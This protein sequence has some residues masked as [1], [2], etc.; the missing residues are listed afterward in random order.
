MSEKALK[1]ALGVLVGLVIVYTVLLVTGREGGA[2]EEGA[3]L[4]RRFAGIAESAVTAVVIDGPGQT[5]EL[6]RSDAG[7]LVNGHATDSAAV[8]RFWNALADFRVQDLVAS[9]PTNHRRL[10]VATDST[11]R[12][13]F[14]DENGEV[15]SILLGNPGTSFSSAYARLPDEDAVYLVEGGLRGAA[16]RRLDDWRDRT[17]LAVDTAAAARVIVRRDEGSRALERTATGWS[18]E[19]MAADTVVVRGI[20]AELADLVATGFAAPADAF[21]GSDTRAVVVESS[22]GDTLGVVEIAGAEGTFLART[23]STSTLF[24][25]SSFRVDRVAPAL[26]DLEAGPDSA[27]T[28]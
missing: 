5:V 19:G 24:K 10:G 11:W 8:A 18:V 26:A 20:L 12:V 13:T 7:W 16:T 27:A 17:I 9:N 28:P 21:E 6:R 15:G 25:L 1:A 23:P 4:A 2:P 14:H 22:T 3:S